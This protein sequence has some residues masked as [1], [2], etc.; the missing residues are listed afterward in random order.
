M[1]ILWIT[2][3]PIPEASKLLNEKPLY[4]GGWLINTSKELSSK[5]GISLSIAFPQK[6]VDSYKKLVGKNITYYGFK[7]VND[8]DKNTI[9]HNQIL[10]R[11]ISDVNPDIVHIHGTEMAHSLSTVNI[12]RKENIEFI[13]SI[14]GLVSIIAKHIYSNLPNRVVKSMTIR[15]ILMKDNV[16]NL[17]KLYTLRG[18]NEIESIKKAKHVIGRTTW[19]RACT[20]Q[21]NNSIEYHF[22]NE[23]LRDEFYKNY[24]N[25]DK[26]EKYSILL[27]QVHYPIK[28]LHYVLE[29]MPHIISEF[30]KTKLYITGN[31]ITKSDSIKDKLSITYYGKYIKGLVKKY[32]L[33]EHIKFLGPLGEKEMCERYLS[34]NV[35]VCPSS[36]EN[37]PNSL[38]EAMLLGVPCVASNVGGIPDLL[39]HK[40]EGFLYPADAPYMLAHYICEIFKSRELANEFSENGRNHAL[41]LYNKNQNNGN[42]IEIYKRILGDNKIKGDRDV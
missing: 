16:K 21:I 23:T 24:W 28:G 6:G 3:I 5:D 25:I 31:N 20:H 15:N 22:C 9:K 12:C 35:F 41:N 1:N 14:Q 42:M 19:D 38:G 11:I 29:A 8:K 2:N 7:P 32:G 40:K 27:S 17:K 13:I 10:Q 30:P 34:S 37:S 33:E 4:Q 36:I 26:C 39:V 18:K